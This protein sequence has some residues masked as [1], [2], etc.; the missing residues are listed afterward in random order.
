MPGADCP[1]DLICS[2]DSLYNTLTSKNLLSYHQLI[3]TL[4]FSFCCLFTTPPCL[5]VI[6]TAGWLSIY[7][8]IFCCHSL[9][10][11]QCLWHFTLLLLFHQPHPPSLVLFFQ[12]LLLSSLSTLATRWQ[13]WCQLH[14]RTACWAVCHLCRSIADF[15]FSPSC[16]QFCLA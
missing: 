4:E 14:H 1:V 12:N 8:F 9:R 11:C 7:I 15:K 16:C 13:C 3:L 5:C 10:C 2:D 6:I